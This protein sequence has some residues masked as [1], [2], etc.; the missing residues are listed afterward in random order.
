VKRFASPDISVKAVE[1]IYNLDRAV[2]VIGLYWYY[3][4]QISFAL[5][6]YEAEIP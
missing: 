1:G 2:T 6:N 5:A 3:H 4:V